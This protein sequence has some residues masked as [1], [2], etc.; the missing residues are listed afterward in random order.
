MTNELLILKSFE[1][2]VLFG[3]SPTLCHSKKE[4][5]GAVDN[6]IDNFPNF[7]C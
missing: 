6:L 1:L 3:K 5:K 4:C 2:F 7:R